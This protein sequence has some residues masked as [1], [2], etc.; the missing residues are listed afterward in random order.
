MENDD[1]PKHCSS[2]TLSTAVSQTVSGSFP[3]YFEKVGGIKQCFW[4]SNPMYKRSPFAAGESWR[5]KVSI[6]GSSNKAQV[7]YLSLKTLSI[8]SEN[9]IFGLLSWFWLEKCTILF[10]FGAD[11]PFQKLIWSPH[12]GGG[13]PLGMSSVWTYLHTESESCNTLPLHRI[14]M[15]DSPFACNL[16]KTHKTWV[17][18]I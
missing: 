2:P 14:C 16:H 3:V 10:G 9:A 12:Y 8:P 6:L 13:G 7:V 5:G 1:F 11:L 17:Q 15:L 4:H 18:N